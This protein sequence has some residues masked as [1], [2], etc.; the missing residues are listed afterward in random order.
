MHHPKNLNQRGLPNPTSV[1]CCLQHWMS[2]IRAD[3]ADSA[4]CVCSIIHSLL[5]WPPLH[6]YAR[7]TV[8]VA[9]GGPL[10]T[11]S[12]PSDTFPLPFPHTSLPSSHMV[13]SSAT[14]PFLYTF[15][16]SARI[17]HLPNSFL[18]SFPIPLPI[19]FLLTANTSYFLLFLPI[20]YFPTNFLFYFLFFQFPLHFSFFF[21]PPSYFCSP[22]FLFSS[23]SSLPTQPRTL[24]TLLLHCLFFSILSLSLSTSHWAPD[25]IYVHASFRQIK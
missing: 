5:F 16:H 13:P 15:A 2:V 11:L 10:H 1:S 8:M 19:Y 24:T 12:P 7:L 22:N 20:P 17:R 3:T 25:L 21:H 18:L 4:R 14:S 9:T 6:G 23:H